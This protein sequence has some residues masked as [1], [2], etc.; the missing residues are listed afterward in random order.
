MDSYMLVLLPHSW[1]SVCIHKIFH[2]ILVWSSV[3][4]SQLN[5]L[6]QWWT[7]ESTNSMV[8]VVLFQNSV[9]ELPD[10]D[11]AEVGL[12]RKRNNK[13]PAISDENEY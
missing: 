12:K 3:L 4:I 1:Y 10:H 7:I 11:F 13:T 9:S 2:E 5:Q 8:T 6:I